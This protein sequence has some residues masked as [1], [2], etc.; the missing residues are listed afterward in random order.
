V[1]TLPNAEYN[2]ADAMNTIEVLNENGDS[3]GG[4]ATAIRTY[5]PLNSNAA[6]VLRSGPSKS[7]VSDIDDAGSCCS[8]SDNIV[9]KG[10]IKEFH[11]NQVFC[12]DASQ[13]DVYESV[14][15]PLVEGLFHNDQQK[16][17]QSALL[18][19]YGITNAGKTHTIMGSGNK[20]YK[21]GSETDSA[22]NLNSGIMPRALHHIIQR[23]EETEASQQ[24]VQLCMSYFE[25]YNEHIFDL[26]PN[27]NSKRSKGS[28]GTTFSTFRGFNASVPLK[29]RESRDGNIFVRGLAKHRVKSVAHG[30]ELALTAKKNR[31]TS[32]NNINSDS[33]RSH[34]ICQ[35]ELVQ[36]NP[37][38]ADDDESRAGSESGY[39]TE[40]E[41]ATISRNKRESSSMWI[42]DLAGS[43]R[44]KRTGVM[45][46]SSRQKEASSINASLMKLMRCL[47]AILNNQQ[48]GGNSSGGSSG[49]IPFRESKLTH[50]FM[51]H[52]T[53]EFASR[54]SMIVNVNPA[55]SDYDETQHVLSY[56]TVARSVKISEV[57]YNRKRRAIAMNGDGDGS[58]TQHTHGTNGRPLKRK[59]KD[60]LQKSSPQKVFKLKK[61]L[62]PRAML[63]RKR[64]QI[65]AA[66]KRKAELQ[67]NREHVPSVAEVASNNGRQRVRRFHTGTKSKKSEEC[68]E[69]KSL[70][71][72]LE[73]KKNEAE[74]LRAESLSLREELSQRESEIRIEIAEEMEHQMTAMREQYNSIIKKLKM[75]L[76]GAPTPGRSARKAKQDKA[77]QIIEEL[78]DKVDECED[79]IERMRDMHE[80]QMSALRSVHEEAVGAKDREIVSLKRLHEEALNASNEKV[81]EL[82]E[83]LE[84]QEADYEE[85]KISKDEILLSYE[86]LKEEIGDDLEDE[87]DSESDTDDD[88][89]KEEGS[90]TPRLRR[91]PRKR[92]SEVACANVPSPNPLDEPQSSNK[93]KFRLLRSKVTPSEEKKEHRVP[94]AVMTA[95]TVNQIASA[96]TAEKNKTTKSRL[97]NALKQ[98][99]DENRE[100][101]M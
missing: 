55:A 20:S 95:S 15:A 60:D 77:E 99:D 27:E 34:C 62:S 85:L 43:E 65:E 81:T 90:T 12:P 94:L 40:Q 36:I 78:M 80:E 68:D 18:F 91:L 45:N 10:G 50:L 82:E 1:T 96:G 7:D 6:K 37:H 83:A 53:G 38:E 28:K 13:A 33:S 21:S 63:K 74:S 69:I 5:P 98:S 79:E 41:E 89:N 23:I 29:L 48:P 2:Y 71:S 75:Q 30:L 22:I 39:S 24:K 19:A 51:G 66:R 8:G 72:S 92:V 97:D 93:K 84:Q 46:M 76:N 100:V 67:S 32:S 44:S 54:T 11:F 59:N 31:H 9:S 17:G 73:E 52:L 64:E 25:I 61:K 58:A 47:Q 26:L 35:L 4:I 88:E 86:E 3:D 14:A 57:D 16:L 56:A 101:T 42:V 49:V 70:R 87:D